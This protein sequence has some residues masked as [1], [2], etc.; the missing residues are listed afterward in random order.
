[1]Q[2]MNHLLKIASMTTLALLITLPEAASAGDRRVVV[3]TKHMTITRSVT[4]APV[5]V[6]QYPN[7]VIY[8]RTPRVIYQGAPTVVIN[9]PFVNARPNNY[10]QQ[11]NRGWNNRSSIGW[12]NR[13]IRQGQP[14]YCPQNRRPTFGQYRGQTPRRW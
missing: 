4:H 14:R 1:M 7:T 3:G 10:Y 2:I 12:R 11:R 6:Q 13:P 9:R 5:V 8:S